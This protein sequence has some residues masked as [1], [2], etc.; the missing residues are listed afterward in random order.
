MSKISIKSVTA[1]EVLDSRGNPTVLARVQLE[2]GAIGE[3]IVP[4]GASTGVKEAVELRDGDK[5]RYGGK[6]VLKAIGHVRETLGPAVIGRDATDQD[7]IDDILIQQDG[8]NNKGRYGANSILSI[9]MAVARA[10]ASALGKPL[11]QHIHELYS[12]DA[13]LNL[14]VPMMNVLNGGVH[15][16]NNIDFQEFMLFPIGAPS[17]AE[18]LR[19]GAETF[20]ILKQLLGERGLSTAVGDEGGFAPNLS[21]NEEPLQLLVE[22]IERAGYVPGKDIAL[23]L[24]PAASEFLRDDHYVFS[25][26]SKVSK[27][28]DDLTA[29][30]E[31]L[32]QKYPIVSLEDGM[33]EEDWLGWM[34]LTATL[35]NKVQLVGDDIFVTNPEVFRR[36]IDKHIGNAILIKLN[37]IGTLTETLETVRMARAANYGAVISHRSGESEDTFIA[38]LAVATGVGQIK[39]GSLSRSERIAKYN[40]LLA[41]EGEMNNPVFGASQFHF[42]PQ[43]RRGGRV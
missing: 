15:A 4:S 3:A 11:Y 24:D 23:C 38:D 2:G 9:S 36:G 19:Y 18:A 41:I 39:T 25:K 5:K 14:P 12:L 21:N 20:H 26:S 37:Q 6:G 33:A 31:S 28:R 22:A 27:T 10:A 32:I 16:S 30:Y 7:S 34:T 43:V 13:P 8:T 35:G 17:F 29:Y 42:K 1:H 40:R